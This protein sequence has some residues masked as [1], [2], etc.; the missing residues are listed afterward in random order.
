[1]MV[2]GINGKSYIAKEFDYNLICD[3]SDMGINIDT[4]M[5]NPYSMC[6]VYLAICG[7]MT[8]A[9]AGNELQAHVLNGNDLSVLTDVITKMMEESGFFLHI[10]GQTESVAEET[11]KKATTKKTTKKA[12]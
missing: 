7:G 1:M 5:S 12:E 9:Q 4:C 3:I 10:T 11:V 2:F 8:L 6:R